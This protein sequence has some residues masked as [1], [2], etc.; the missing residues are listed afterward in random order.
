MQYILTEQEYTAL[1]TRQ[2]HEI[3]LSRDK[4]QA[5]CTKIAETM[6]VEVSW[7]RGEPEPWG[8]VL[9]SIHGGY[10]DECPV[11]EICPYE[12]KEWSQ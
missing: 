12:D 2:A 11:Q 5:L 10:C 6:P 8:C 1:K 7:R 4:L 9:D 3:K